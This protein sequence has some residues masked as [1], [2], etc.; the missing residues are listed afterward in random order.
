MDSGAESRPPA[1]FS[2]FRSDLVAD[3]YRT[4][5]REASPWPHVVVDDLLDPAVLA[6]AESEEMTY[7]LALPVRHATRQIKAESPAVSG[8][9]AQAILDA[10]SG[11]R[12][13]AFLEDLTGISHLIPDPA[14]YWAG[15]HV[16][17][18]G[19][20]QGLHRDFRVHPVSRLFHR[21]N[22]IV[23][24]NSGWRSEYGGDLELWTSELTYCAG[25]VAPHAGT[26]VIF[27][28][29]SSALHGVPDPIRCP[30]DR[31]R[32]SLVSNYYTVTP[33]PNNPRES[34][35]RRPKRPVDPWYM[36]YPAVV[37]LLIR[38]FRKFLHPGDTVPSSTS[39]S[40]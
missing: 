19:A 11:R 39:D 35:V 28:S 17:P 6:A 12:F 15:L 30:A 13:I 10:L 31:A 32:L 8:P 3:A 29:T 27:E 16:F 18:P 1:D 21:V 34:L 37:G 24:L 36:A 25:R 7:A 26:T 40:P 20:F 23:Y 4:K 5:Y 2:V 22:V 33:G 14:H 38:E 9:S